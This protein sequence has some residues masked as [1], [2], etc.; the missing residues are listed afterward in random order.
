VA[1]VSNEL[2]IDDRVEL[3]PGKDEVYEFAVAGAQGRIIGKK[4]EDGFPMVFIEW[5]ENHW[6][7]TGEPDCWTFESHFRPAEESDSFSIFLECVF[8]RVR[9]AYS[10]EKAEQYTSKLESVLDILQESDG[11]LLITANRIEDEGHEVLVPIISSGFAREDIMV[12]LE[13]QLIQMAAMAHQEMAMSILSKM[14]E[15]EEDDEE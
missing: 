1:K 6:R 5:D 12:V 3:I 10:I 14:E 11:F 8:E 4:D 7:Y 13:A 9:T 2:E 15:N